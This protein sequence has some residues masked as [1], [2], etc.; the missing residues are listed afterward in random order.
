MNDVLIRQPRPKSKPLPIG[1]VKSRYRELR[2]LSP[3]FGPKLFFPLKVG[4]RE[5]VMRT[6]PQFCDE[7]LINAI[8]QDHTSKPGYLMRMVTGA[9]RVDLNGAP[10]GFV[11]DKAAEIATK[12][13][14]QIKHQSAPKANPALS[15]ALKSSGGHH[16]PIEKVSQSEQ[17]R[18][19]LSSLGSIA[20]PRN[21]AAQTSLRKA[22]VVIVKRS[23]AIS[24]SRA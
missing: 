5:D 14:A 19:I 2:K 1:V 12:R 11:T 9:Q 23:R 20:G 22:P 4:I 15:P 3:V 21:S 13:L 24:A 10:A 6:H 7:R 16:V 8:M 18:H 17:C